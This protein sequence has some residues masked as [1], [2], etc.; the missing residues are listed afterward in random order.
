MCLA[1]NINTI[2]FHATLLSAYSAFQGSI[3][4]H[5]LPLF[6]SW[7]SNYMT[8]K[9]WSESFIPSQTWEW[10]YNFIQHSIMHT[11]SMQRLKLRHVSKRGSS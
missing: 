4:G 10:T 5:G 7:I 6:S 1:F 3:Y 8:S 9:V 11:L 2:A